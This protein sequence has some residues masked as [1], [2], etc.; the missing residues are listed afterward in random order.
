MAQ[1]A[2]FP[3]STTDRIEFQEFI[4]E[5]HLFMNKNRSYTQQYSHLYFTRLAQIQK[6]MAAVCCAKWRGSGITQ[7]S[8]ILD[9]QLEK[10]CICIGTLYKEMALKPN[11]L[12]DYMA[13]IVNTAVED[14][15]DED[16]DNEDL[17]EP[18]GVGTTYHSDTDQ[19][20]LEDESGRMTLTSAAE[21]AVTAALSQLVTGVIIGVKGVWKK[22]ANFLVDD[23][24]ICGVPPQAH[25]VPPALTARPPPQYLGLVSGLQL[26]GGSAGGALKGSPPWV[27]QLL[28]DF[29]CG[30]AGDTEL[31]RQ[32]ARLVV[33]GNSIGPTEEIKSKDKIQLHSQTAESSSMLKPLKEL[34]SL[35]AR[36]CQGLP[37]DVVPGELDPTNCFLPQQPIHPCLLPLT[38]KCPTASF[39]PNPYQVRINGLT[40]L[41]TAGQPVEDIGKYTPSMTPLQVLEST[42]RWRNLAPTAPD[43]LSVYPFMMEDPFT[44]KQCPHVYF[45]GNQPKFETSLLRTETGVVCRLVCVPAFCEVPVLVLVDMASPELDVRTVDFTAVEPS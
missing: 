14:D 2:D 42:L 17:L 39:T 27:L 5:H 10:P 16:Q 7:V 6:E 24:T 13:E 45:A 20:I 26:L 28:G 37:V 33:A 21:A 25:S 32:V 19:S 1:G 9:V 31:A 11:F 30:V 43:T 44:L 22:S 4:P 41:G 35:L 18:T 38:A 23:L 36:L 29:L 15:D 40:V 12:R 34:D 3:A 8:R